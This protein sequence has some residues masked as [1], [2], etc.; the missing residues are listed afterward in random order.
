MPP[1]G[2]PQPSDADRQ[3]FGDWLAKLKYLSQK[4]PGT[5]R[6]PAVDKDRIRQ[7]AA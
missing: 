7:H 6:H 5:F 2:V 4:D 1:K 3:M